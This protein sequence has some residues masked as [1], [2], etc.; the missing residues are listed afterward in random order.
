MLFIQMRLGPMYTMVLID[1]VEIETATDGTKRGLHKPY[2]KGGTLIY[3]HAGNRD[4]W[5]KG[6]QIVLRVIKQVGIITMN[7][8]M[9]E[10]WF[11]HK[12][13]ITL[14]KEV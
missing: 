5:I 10:Q 7:S 6:A 3:W 14:Q 13:C 11:H 9:Y 12:L 4:G 2:C 8:D 1:G